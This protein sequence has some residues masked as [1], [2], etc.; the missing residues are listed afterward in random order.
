MKGQVRDMA[1]CFRPLH[2]YAPRAIEFDRGLPPCP[3]RWRLFFERGEMKKPKIGIEFFTTPEVRLLRARRGA[4]AVL[5]YIKLLSIRDNSSALT[6]SGRPY[7]DEELAIAI[8]ENNGEVKKTRSALEDIGLAAEGSIYA[9]R[10]PRRA[11]GDNAP[12]EERPAKM[13]KPRPTKDDITRLIEHLNR[14][15]GRNYDPQN[16]YNRGYIADAMSD[17]ATYE[18]CKGIIDEKSREWQGTDFAK[19][20][21]PSTLFGER[22]P[23]YLEKYRERKSKKIK[24]TTFTAEEAEKRALER[25]YGNGESDKPV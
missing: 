9:P 17:G 2:N 6:M 7:T 3:I 19:Y 22:F 13:R 4:E 15:A 21:R 10:E 11:R 8:E 5:I 1:R 14:K 20:L 16:E 24:Y 25:S 12:S 23:G 18:E